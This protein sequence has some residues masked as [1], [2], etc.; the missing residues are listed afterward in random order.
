MQKEE[1]GVPVD[2]ILEQGCSILSRRR[3][4]KLRASR[5][6][7]R[8]KKIGALQPLAG[9][10]FFRSRELEHLVHLVMGSWLLRMIDSLSF[11]VTLKKCV[12]LMVRAFV[13]RWGFLPLS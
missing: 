12:G 6:D 2:R 4:Q 9:N 10:E 8:L 7:Q 13:G 1:K 11:K 3:S 5:P